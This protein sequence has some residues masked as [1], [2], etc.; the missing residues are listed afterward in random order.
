MSESPPPS[1]L[2]YSTGICTR[3]SHAG[4]LA[5]T[6]SPSPESEDVENFKRSHYTYDVSPPCHFSTTFERHV[7][8][9]YPG[10]YI[11]SRIDNPTRK[12]LELTLADMENGS[13]AVSFASG[14]AAVNAVLQALGPH[15]LILLTDDCYHGVR[16]VLIELFSSWNMRYEIVDMTNISEIEVYLRK[17]TMPNYGAGTDEKENSTK[18]NEYHINNIFIW[19]ESPSNPLLKV[20][21]VESIVHLIKEYRKCQSKCS[22]MSLIDTTWLT[23]LLMRPLEMGVDFVLHSVTKYLSGHS[24]V[25]GGVLI[26]KG[27]DQIMKQENVQLN[28]SNNE[29]EKN[30]NDKILIDGLSNLEVNEKDTIEE[31]PKI[32]QEKKISVEDYSLISSSA[33]DALLQKIIKVQQQ[34]GAVPSPFDCWLILRGIR[35]LGA[36]MRLHCENALKIARFLSEEEF[37]PKVISNIHYPGLESHPQHAI[38][39]RQMLNGARGKPPIGYGGMMSIQVAGGKKNAVDFIAALRLFRRATSLGGTESLIE[40]RASVEG[41][42]SKTPDNLIRLSIGLEDIEDLIEDLMRGIKAVKQS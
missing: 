3:A 6:T 21:D 1:A 19:M 12:Q 20:I 40:H 35:S 24:D 33:T 31:N 17:Y 34:A 27:M 26:G 29:K 2:S 7:D 41:L 9:S 8:L 30:S 5:S 32:N 22:I 14:M 11:Y 13:S 38:F 16:T 28:T 42:Y 37:F 4:Y 18:R 39:K 25:L 10:G 23:P 15:T 36:R